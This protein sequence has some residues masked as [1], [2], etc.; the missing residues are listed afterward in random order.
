MKPFSIRGRKLLLTPFLPLTWAAALVLPDF[1]A[2]A[3][4]VL[5][6]LHSFQ[7][8]PNGM[9]PVA[10][11]VQ[12]SD[13][14][15]YGTT[16]AGGTNGGNGTVFKI[17]TNGALTSL[18]SFTFVN[19][20]SSPNGLLQGRD[21]KFYGTASNGGTNDGG[22]MFRIS[23]N[24]VRDTL[25]SFTRGSDGWHPEAGLVQGLDGS[26]YGTTA[27]G[28][29]NGG[30]GT[31]FK[32]SANGALTTLYTF[33]GGTDGAFPQ[34]A[35]VPGSDG[36]FYGTTAY[37]GRGIGN[38]GYGTVFKISANGALT[39]LYSFSGGNDGSYPNGLVE[40]ND[41]SFYGTMAY[42]GSNGVF[43]I[44][45][46][47]VLTSL[48]SFTGGADGARPATAL[49]Q[50]SDGEFYGITS[51]GGTDNVGTVF[52]ISTNGALTT[53]YS[54]TG[55][56]DGVFPQA[57]LVQG[58]DGNFYGTTFGGG[59]GG[60][61]FRISSNGDLTTLYSFTGSTTD[62]AG[63]WAGLV[64]GE[65]GNLYGT[66][67]YGGTNGGGGTVF[68]ISANGALTSLY[69]FTGGADGN[70]P[71]AALVQGSDRKLYGTTQS[72]GA[73]G[74][75]FGPRYG[76]VFQISTNGALTS[77]YSFTGGADGAY[78]HAGLVQGTDG[79]FY[80]T[81]SGGTNG[82]G[83]VFKITTNGT[84]TSLYSFKG[85]NDGASPSAGLVQGSD[86][87]LYGTTSGYHSGN[88]YRN[89]T[90]FRIS[91]N[92]VLATLYSFTGGSDGWDPE[93]G[94]VQGLDGKFYGTT[95]SG[96]ANGFGTV[97]QISSDGALTTLYSFTGSDGAGP[98]AGLVQGSDGCFYGTTSS[99]GAS[100]W[101]TVFKITTNGVLTSLYSFTG[102]NDGGNPQA[103]LVQGRDATFYGTTSTGS[104]GGAGT[105]FR[106]TIV[107][108]FQAVTLTKDVLNLT[109]ST[110][111]GG[112][113]QLQYT[114]DLNSSN[115]T[116]L[117]GLRTAA[118]TIL[119]AT[120]PA[121]NGP[122][123]F[124]RVMRLP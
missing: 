3:A 12:G 68:R 121:T 20:G 70:R 32:I 18:Y 73:Y 98:S 100:D 31:M 108:E 85:T 1:S 19:D 97:F 24:G 118:A 81:T 79:N 38:A 109:W 57:A 29:T 7:V 92:G 99:G 27:Y 46:N 113:Y 65:D 62:G 45:T 35:L 67:H 61:V 23:A 84:L 22:T 63:P 111:A 80:G 60:T 55:G 104:V 58:N 83:N 87:N 51:E 105:V 82:W 86:G 11:L 91:A 95:Q 9:S 33:T 106:L 72:G 52:R 110:E 8:L 26:F 103:G 120:D 5:T 78:P 123:R 37:G 54:F 124:Y 4:A 115:W 30:Y 25:Y 53:L 88:I 64:L 89:G 122:A 42:G 94:L 75:E 6:S 43:R 39:S 76:T 50:G 28:E 36:N 96:G 112:T 69:S 77:S 14:F 66:T 102:G 74:P 34:A 41:G 21:G 117:D 116:D 48:Y 13:G 107:P 56:N 90:V 17:S 44:S 10:G 47:G 16:S 2:Q 93:A 15:L 40:G 71:A 101:G 49:V 59:S 114:S 119:S